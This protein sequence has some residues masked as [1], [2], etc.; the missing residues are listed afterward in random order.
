MVRAIKKQ[1]IKRSLDMI[2]EIAGREKKEDYET[3]W[4]AFGRNLKLGVIEDSSNRDALAKLLR[5]PSTASGEGMTSLEG[6][7]G[8]KKEGQKFIYYLAGMAASWPHCTAFGVAVTCISAAPATH[9][10][11]HAH[12]Y[13]PAVPTRSREP[14]C[15]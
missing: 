12:L 11:K 15:G 2:A 3:F 13:T 5:F 10:E 14:G 1:L 8:R 9:R 6:Y 7:V 4:E